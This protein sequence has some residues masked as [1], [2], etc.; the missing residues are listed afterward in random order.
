[1]RAT[2][3]LSFDHVSWWHIASTLQLEAAFA[4]GKPVAGEAMR[5]EISG[6]EMR[7]SAGVAPGGSSTS[8][9]IVGDSTTGD[10]Y[11]GS[12]SVRAT[13]AAVT[14]KGSVPWA[15]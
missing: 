6:A 5:C 1:M 15:P 2:A 10:Q 11:S 12:V 7:T 8:I 13:S 14:S 3:L 9:T 4:T